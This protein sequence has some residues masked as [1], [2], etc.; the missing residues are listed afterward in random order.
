M[1]GEHFDLHQFAK[2]AKV[3]TQET[4]ISFNDYRGMHQEQ[5]KGFARRQVHE[6]ATDDRRFRDVLARYFWTAVQCDARVYPKKFAEVSFKD[7]CKFID[8]FAR[9]KLARRNGYRIALRRADPNRRRKLQPQAQKGWVSYRRAVM[10]GYTQVYLLVA[11]RYLRFGLNS[12]Q[13]C[14]GLPISPTAVRQVINRL[15]SIA[16]VYYPELVPPERGYGGRKGNTKA[17]VREHVGPTADVKK[18][19]RRWKP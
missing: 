18:T 9:Q 19:R 6:W 1:S 2:R 4:E 5:R 17:T 12:V 11:W 3:V 10:C 7:F 16:R 13:A 14:E 15:T 8:Y